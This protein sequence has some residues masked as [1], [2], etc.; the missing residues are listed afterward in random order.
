MNRVG[1]VHLLR[2]VQP[3]AIGLAAL[4]SLGGPAS[5]G[6][7]PPA[8]PSLVLL[9]LDTTRADSIGCYGAA[10]A[11]TPNLD[12]L[13]A[14]G[15]R[16]ARALTSSP[17][18]FPAHCSLMTGLDPPFHGVR[19][20]GTAI[21]PS[22][23][24]TLA[25]V[26]RAR[27]YATGAFVSSRVL[28]RR[29]GLD[30]GFR[31]YDER[32]AAERQ[33]EHGYPER[34]AQ[35]VTSAALTWLSRL[36]RGRPY[37]LWVHYY[38]P[39]SPYAPPGDWSGASIERRYAGEVAYMDREIGRLLARLPARDQTLVAAVGDHGE[40]L[41]EHGERDHGLLLY[42]SSLEV[43][44]I[45]A[46]PGVPMGRVVPQTVGTRALPA[47][48]FALLKTGGARPFGAPLPGLSIQ[49]G[50]APSGETVY[51]ETWLPATAYGW[52]PLRAA[53]DSR[54]RFVLA[55]RPELYDFVSD[56]GETKNIMKERG[57][58]AE[59]L[60]S[61]LADVE[62]RS[63]GRKAP[64][65]APPPEVVAALR[66]LGYLSGSSPSR[67]NSLD[68]KD[69]VAML[70]EFDR[71]NEAMVEGR[72][73]EALP[74]LEDLVRRSPGNVP[75]LS[76]LSDVQAVLGK[77]E[78]ALATVKE[79]IGLNPRLDFLHLHLANTYKMLGRFPDARAEYQAALAL[80]PRMSQAWLAL[81]ELAKRTGQSAEE[82]RLLERAVAAGTSS[83]AILARLAQIETAAGDLGAAERHASEATGLV[84]EFAAG[85]WVSGEVAAKSGRRREAIARYE[86]AVRLGFGDAR[87]YVELAKLLL[88]EKQTDAARRYLERAATAGGSSPAASEARRLLSGIQ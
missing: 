83:A 20:N 14:R 22:S 50:A 5:G 36:P 30:R 29:F 63:A 74:V 28:D 76:R 88:A 68:P 72:P 47:T 6:A 13:A 64:G 75:F 62:R 17:L 33:G 25:T 4:V 34:D 57:G 56:P 80:N 58:D 27:G 77:S 73:A 85:W 21:L 84:P 37:F 69:G 7:P 38:D 86:E 60:R 11:A 12:A 70:A 42:R 87:A 3:W 8:R 45:L 52:S 15:T 81:G 78:D 53:S 32:M 67:A 10:R 16:Y 35:A 55:P 65:A 43:P 24:P 26:L 66:S 54:L 48:L 46:G 18:T 41:G 71:A 59:R 23:L 1:G 39:H 19:D 49:G 61:L 51:S 9:T 79:A 31:T 40:M 82:R 44:L 2:I